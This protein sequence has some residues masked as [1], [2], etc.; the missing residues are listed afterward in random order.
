MA[1]VTRISKEG[2]SFLHTW[3]LLTADAVGDSLSFPGVTV[4]FIPTN[5]GGATVILEGSLDDRVFFPL[6]DRQGNT[7]SFTHAGGVTIEENV[8]FYRPRLLITGVAADWVVQ[9]LSR[10][11]MR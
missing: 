10:S 1:R 9:L 6:T 7:I 11:T 3:N 8:L 2:R 5:S 4:Q